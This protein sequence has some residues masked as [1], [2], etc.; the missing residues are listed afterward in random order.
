MVGRLRDGPD[1][2]LDVDIKRL[3]AIDMHGTSGTMRRRRVILVEFTAGLVVMASL[4]A[5]LTASASDLALSC[6]GPG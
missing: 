6:L 1:R 2:C 5:W 4:G 3:A